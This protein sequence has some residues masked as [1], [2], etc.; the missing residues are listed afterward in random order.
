M[1]KLLL[2]AVIVLLAAGIQAQKT[3]YDPNAEL[4]NAK[5]FH[6][7]QVSSGIDL[8]LTPGDEAV[9]VSAATTE[10]RNAIKTEVQNGVLKIWIDWRDGRK[11]NHGN[12]KMKAYVS[13]KTLNAIRAS[14]GS[15]VRVEGTISTNSL[16]ISISGGSDFNGRV[17]VQELKVDQSG[18]SD[19]N[20]SGTASMV[21]VDANGGSDFNGFDLTADTC[22]VE[23]SGGSDVEIT[24]NKE[25]TARL[26]GASDLS[27]KGNGAVKN[28]NTSGSSRISRK[29]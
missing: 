10:V 15:D 13:F 3:V 12:K 20:I 21:Q 23:A 29:S 25:L 16:T 19:V 7:V 4:R 24:V 9:A 1:K 22:S 14:G 11:W 17:A 2:L 8:L 5:D 28:V 27:Y 6:T 26:S 18:G